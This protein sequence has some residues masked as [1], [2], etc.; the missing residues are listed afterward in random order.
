VALSRRCRQ[1]VTAAVA[2]TAATPARL[3]MN[4][5]FQLDSAPHV[6]EAFAQLIR[7]CCAHKAEARPTFTAVRE[8]LMLVTQGDAAAWA[9]RTQPS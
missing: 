3:R 6:S 1:T 4:A 8:L 2:A 7:S 9:N 5:E